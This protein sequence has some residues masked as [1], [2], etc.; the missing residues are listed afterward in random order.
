MEC[1]KCLVIKLEMSVRH[2]QQALEKELQALE[3]AKAG[4]QQTQG[5]HHH[6]SRDIDLEGTHIPF[7]DLDSDDEADPMDK[8]EKPLVRAKE[9]KIEV[10]EPL[11]EEDERMDEE[12][13]KEFN[14][15]DIPH[16]PT[17]VGLEVTQE[18][19]QEEDPE[20]DPEED[21]EEMDEENLMQEWDHL[22]LGT[23]SHFS[24]PQQFSLPS[25]RSPFDF[26]TPSSPPIETPLTWSELALAGP[27]LMIVFQ[28]RR[29]NLIYNRSYWE[30]ERDR[31][32]Q[33][34]LELQS[35]VDSLQHIASTVEEDISQAQM[36]LD[37]EGRELLGSL[38]KPEFLDLF[39][40]PPDF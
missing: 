28:I 31:L 13:V 19:D 22:P 18:V 11:V 37:N 20:E 29:T 34:I 27:L 4:I 30:E 39:C 12:E 5:V 33:R 3:V 25:P 35:V 7:V 2:D 17:E 8:D 21:L 40:E 24:S 38:F 26:P 14:L 23:S 15:S 1:P 10:G 9:P 6:V 16:G 32:N 36:L